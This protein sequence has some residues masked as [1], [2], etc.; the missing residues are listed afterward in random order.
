MVK[1][2]KTLAAILPPESY[3]VGGF[4]RDRLLGKESADIDL[5]VP[6]NP[7]E[8]ARRVAEVLKGHLFG[9]KKNIDTRGEV[10]TVVVP[11]G[12]KKLRIDI[13]GYRDLPED[14]KSRDFTINAMA[15]GLGD[16][17]RGRFEPIDPLGGLED[18]KRG[19]IR[20]TSFRE[21]ERDPVRMLRA[22]RFASQLNFKIEPA[23][24]GFVK[25][26]AALLRTAAPERVVQ[27]LLKGGRHGY[28]FFEGLFEDNLLRALFGEENYPE[29]LKLVKNAEGLKNLQNLERL[30]SGKT[31][32]GE[33]SEEDILGWVLL[34]ST[35]GDLSAAEKYPFGGEFFKYLRGARE[36]FENLRGL[37]FSDAEALGEY[38][39]RFKDY[40]YPIGILANLKGLGK[41]FE[42]LSEFFEKVYKPY[43]KPLIGGKRVAEILGIKPSPLVGKVLKKLRAEQLRGRVKTEREAEEFVK[44]LKGKL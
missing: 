8:V 5:I 6:E 12:E 2:L 4:V 34:F 18:L 42:K 43:G 41:E 37:N 11:L 44:T 32:L 21:L 13:S 23:T 35:F 14:L 39:D 7:R 27:E 31:F 29:G 30:K 33:F 15:V 17:A 24:R 36:G 38:L 28:T 26:R 3:L 25:E 20:A 9:F 22:H 19:I 1:V 40:L 16:F 10:Y